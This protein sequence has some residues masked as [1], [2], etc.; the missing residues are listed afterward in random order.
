M[1]ETHHLRLG[2]S[3]PWGHIYNDPDRERKNIEFALQIAHACQLNLPQ[4]GLLQIFIHK[5]GCRWNYTHNEDK[6]S[7]NDIASL[8][9]F[10]TFLD[11]SANTANNLPPYL[12]LQV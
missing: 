3:L 12:W 9:N 7:G 5:S 4:E 11:C 2:L 1:V 6:Q 8:L 10:L